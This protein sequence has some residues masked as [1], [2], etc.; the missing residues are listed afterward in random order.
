MKTS[1]LNPNPD[2]TVPQI[3]VI[4]DRC[5]AAGMAGDEA[6]SAIPDILNF[7]PVPRRAR[8]DGW[9][10]EHQRAFIAALAI[11]G[12]PRQA[13]R[14]IGRHQFGAEQLRNA[15]A[16]KSFAIAW[17]AAIDLAREREAFRIHENL[18]GLAAERD[19]QLASI[20]HSSRRGE[21]WV[22]GA[23]AAGGLH[24]DCDYDPELHT[25]DYPEYWEGLNRIRD[26][27]LRA[28]RML[29]F[30]IRNDEEKR[31]AWE[32]LVGPADW[33]LA[34]DLQPQP[35]EPQR[36]EIMNPQGLPN[37]TRPDMLLTAEAGLLPEMVGG[38]DLLEDIRQA[39]AAA[40]EEE[41]V[42]PERVK[43]SDRTS[44]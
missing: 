39:V 41:S 8:A 44:T 29:L 14:A 28:R 40:R 5:R 22:E 23:L 36:G 33:D 26:R 3:P 17:D 1:E 21:G 24:P 2:L 30:L 7:T 25:E 10:E 4:C 12:S 11:T 43:G 37:L 32:V 6:F 38:H 16:G 35:D 15:R 31:R 9:K 27:L 19:A 20:S 42:R 18:A 13:A 34:D